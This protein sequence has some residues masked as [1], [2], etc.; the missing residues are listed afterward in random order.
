MKRKAQGSEATE[1]REALWSKAT[2]NA[3]AKRETRGSEA[4]AGVGKVA[5]R[6][7]LRSLRAKRVKG[8]KKIFFAFL[9][10][11]DHFQS[12]ETHFFFL[13]ISSERSDREC[14]RQARSAEGAKRP[15]SP[16]GLA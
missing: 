5:L 3:S 11:L 12:I 10:G 6:R 15:S 13:K 9:C 16:A 14:E 2:E 8:V 1:K 4:T 7:S